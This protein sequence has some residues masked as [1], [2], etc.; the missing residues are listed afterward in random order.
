MINADSSG[1]T[2]EICV[3]D[4]LACVTDYTCA[5]HILLEN[6]FTALLYTDN[7]ATGIRYWYH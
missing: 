3:T 7:I 6:Q 5:V 1:D 2:D 4:V